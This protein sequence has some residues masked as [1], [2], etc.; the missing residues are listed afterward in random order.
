[1]ED[2]IAIVAGL[3]AGWRAYAAAHPAADDFSRDSGYLSGLGV[4]AQQLEDAIARARAD[5]EV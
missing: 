4:C 1:M 2:F 5:A 3:A